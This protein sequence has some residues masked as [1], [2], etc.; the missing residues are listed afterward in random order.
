MAQTVL[1]KQAAP[2]SM[3]GLVD[4]TEATIK[5]LKVNSD[6][7]L[8][9]NL[10]T[11][12][13]EIGAVEI[14]DGTTDN[15]QSIKVDNAT[16]TATPTVAL[17]GGVYKATEDTYDDNDASP[18]H[19]DSTGN[20]KVT[21][22]ASSV[23]AEYTSPSD[24][25]ATYTSASTLTLSSLPFTISDSSQIVYV[26]QILSGNTSDIYVNG[27]S[28]I[29]FAVSSNVLTV[30]KS[31]VVITT[32]ASGDVYEVGINSQKKAYDPSTQTNLVSVINW[33]TSTDPQFLVT[34][35]DIGAADGTYIDQGAEISM[36]TK[37]NTLGLFVKF[38]VSDS[39]TN[40]LK[41]LSKRASAGA[42]EFV[43]ETAGDYIKT[44]GDSS[45]NIFYEFDTSA[46]IPYIQVQTA[47]ADID[48]GG[49][50]EGTLEI[51]Y[52]LGRK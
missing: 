46:L 14:K 18:L 16:A 34:A 41:V 45:I 39:T 27:S 38:T 22:G 50:T 24:F 40:T 11:S 48:S 33:I 23:T 5:P 28:G 17:V 30:Y 42:E 49:G 31:G 6:G 2:V 9:I 35:S 4:G 52:V 7:E 10:E 1:D 19:M 47:A 44:L 32:L 26:K 15:R 3:Y 12:D 25:T 36:G 37:Y 13:I 43:L 29:T 51:Y 20:L 8:A 21:G